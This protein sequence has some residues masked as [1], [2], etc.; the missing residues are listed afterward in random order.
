MVPILY[1]KRYYITRIHTKQ[2]INYLP[3]KPLLLK[4]IDI[5]CEF[6]SHMIP[7]QEG[8]STPPQ[9]FVIGTPL[10]EQ[11]HTEESN[12]IPWDSIPAAKSQR[13]RS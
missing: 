9:G 3:D 8:I 4:E 2:Y 13:L 11:F 1:L 7:G 10:G 12:I 5:T 6:S